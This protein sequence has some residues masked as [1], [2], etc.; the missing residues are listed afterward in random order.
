MCQCDGDSN[1]VKSVLFDNP[2]FGNTS[3]NRAFTLIVDIFEE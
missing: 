2:V 3:Q 1:D